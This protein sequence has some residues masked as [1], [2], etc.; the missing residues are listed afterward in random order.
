VTFHK[1]A[2]K[3]Y[4]FVFIFTFTA[5]VVDTTVKIHN[6]FY[7]ILTKKKKK[8]I[9]IINITILTLVHKIFYIVITNNIIHNFLI[10]NFLCSYVGCA[11]NTSIHLLLT[12]RPLN[13]I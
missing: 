13:T 4:Y 1:R 9:K 11:F 12:I 2:I 7:Q 6:V 8:Q 5:L 10:L 3:L